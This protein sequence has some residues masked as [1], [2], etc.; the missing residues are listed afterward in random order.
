MIGPVKRKDFQCCCEAWTATPVDAVRHHGV[1][2]AVCAEHHHPRAQESMQ[3]EID[4]DDTGYV[5]IPVQDPVG[6]QQ[7]LHALDAIKTL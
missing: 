3:M 5:V 1:L 6:H 7:F 4:M 2:Y